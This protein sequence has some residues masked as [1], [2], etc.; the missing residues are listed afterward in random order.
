MRFQIYK[1][2][3]G[4]RWRL[5]AKNGKILA[6]SGEAYKRKRSLFHAIDLIRKGAAT[7]YGEEMENG[8]MSRVEFVDEG[9]PDE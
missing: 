7:S 9:D 2:A 8:E 5:Y 3:D 1:A 6:D 4:W